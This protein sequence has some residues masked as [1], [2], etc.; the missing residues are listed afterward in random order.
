MRPWKRTHAA[1]LAGLTVVA[2]TGCGE[3]GQASDPA[4]T[5]TL[6]LPSAAYANQCAPDNPD[7]DPSQRSGSRRTEMAWLRAMLQERYL[8]NE[9]LPSLNMSAPVYQGAPGQPVDHV[10]ALN[11]WLD[12][13]VRPHGDTSRDRFSYRINTAEKDAADTGTVAGW[14]V[15]LAAVTEHPRRIAIT[16]IDPLGPA[17]QAG[18]QRGDEVVSLDGVAVS[19]EDAAQRAQLDDRLLSAPSG[20]SARWVWRRGGTTEFSQTVVAQAFQSL[21]VPQV[22]VL[23]TADGAPG[24]VG[25]LLFNEFTQPAQQALKVAFTQLAAA[26]VRD[27]VLDLRYNG[28]GQGF[29]ASQLAYMVAGQATPNR[30]FNRVRMNARRTAAGQ[31]SDM[32]FIATTCLDGDDRCQPGE[33]LPTLNLRRVFVLTGPNTCSASE[34]LING[35]RGVDI[36]VIQVGSG[37]CGKPYGYEGASNCGVTTFAIE[38]QATNAKGFGD[39]VDGFQPGGTGPTGL[40]GCNA[41]DDLTHALGDP[42]E[43]MLATALSFR[44]SGQCPIATAQAGGA[45][46]GATQTLRPLTTRTA[47]LDLSTGRSRVQ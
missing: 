15:Q 7:A 40:P 11:R 32:P 24:P 20:T 38:M 41:Q 36:E 30:V 18:M 16:W 44:S 47:P 13:L 5:A 2:L 28:G 19:V 3:G 14:G 26:Q 27:L 10:T 4:A 43:Q 46:S 45:R 25:Y 23:P 1:W 17:A 42:E 22:K 9:D 29:I 34:L 37:T 6:S 12:D 35:L 33:P 8:W 21:A 39:Y 31:A